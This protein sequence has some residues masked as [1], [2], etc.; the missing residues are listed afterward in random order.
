[1]GYGAFGPENQQIYLRRSPKRRFNLYRCLFLRITKWNQDEKRKSHDKPV[2]V[3][4]EKKR[5][6]TLLAK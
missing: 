3:P 4:K 5:K 2:R 6:P 1:M